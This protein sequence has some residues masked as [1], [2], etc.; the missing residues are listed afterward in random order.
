MPSGRVS[1][2]LLPSHGLNLLAEQSDWGKFD[3]RPN[4]ALISVAEWQ[5]LKAGG[6]KLKQH[7]SKNV[8]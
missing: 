6:L 5:Q 7:T 8:M 1:A 2:S 4:S 3:I